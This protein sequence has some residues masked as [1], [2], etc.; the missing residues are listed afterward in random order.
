MRFGCCFI[1]LDAAARST[2]QRKKVFLRLC[3]YSSILCFGLEIANNKKHEPH[4]SRVIIPLNLCFG[5]IA[6]KKITFFI[7]G[8]KNNEN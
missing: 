7:L 3:E 8:G 4:Y 6:N 2:D 1:I 5:I